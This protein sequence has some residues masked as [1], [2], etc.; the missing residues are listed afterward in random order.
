[1]KA[2]ID[3]CIIIDALQSRAPFSTEA[4]NIFLEAANNSFEGYITANATTDIYYLMHKYF[5]N[6]D[7]TRKQLNKLLELFNIADTTK[8]DCIDAL[9]GN[10]SDYED[11]VLHSIAVREKADCIV[12][13][14]VSDFKNSNIP[15]YTPAQFLQVL[16]TL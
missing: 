14:N 16:S 11:A 9:N 5:N 1:M 6:N 12:T 4:Q 8:Q 15:I 3:T 7:D 10:I 2:I 13:R